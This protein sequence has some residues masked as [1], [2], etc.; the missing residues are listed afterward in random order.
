MRLAL[1]CIILHQ[2]ASAMGSR[3]YL[4]CQTDH[5]P[6]QRREPMPPYKR[7]AADLREKISTMRA[8][9]QIPSVTEITVAYGVSRNTAL[10]AIRLLR[11]EGLITVEQGWGS[12]VSEQ[13]S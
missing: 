11:D 9:E 13:S 3:S 10:R 2:L 7:I 4:E 1:A 12:F 6:E 8:G 5:V